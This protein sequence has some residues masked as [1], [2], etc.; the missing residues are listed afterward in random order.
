MSQ[1]LKDS[2][3][4][5]PGALISILLIAA[6]IYFVDIPK[7]I[8]AI[9]AANYVII[10]IAFV[11]G[12]AWLWVRAIVWRTLLRERASFWDVFHSL[13]VGYLLNAFLPLRLGELG[14]AYLLSLK[15]DMTFVEIL[16]TIVIERSMDLAITAAI[17]LSALPFVAGVKDADRIAIILGV[18][19]LAGLLFLY[20]L[21]RNDQW[22]LDT[23]HKVSAR[24]PS[25]QR[26]GG[27]ILESFL[28]GLGALTNGWLFARFMFWMLLNWGMS[29][30]TFYLVLI[31]FFP[32][33]QWIWALFGLGAGAFGNAVPSLPGAVGTYEGALGGALTLVSNDQNTSLAVALTLHFLNY[34]TAIV[35]GGYALI[36][37]GQSLSGVY[38][39]L[40]N[41]RSKGKI[42]DGD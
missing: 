31:A 32:H 42:A 7:M 21:A 28:T 13:N 27:S 2:K 20:I 9:R 12:F 29:I 11:I 8:A 24:W 16:P 36:R 22:A 5:L 37:G 17:F 19:V 1:F 41:L 23:F 6:I 3:R 30:V 14:R 15:T 39:Q 26:F 10:L 33:P 35:L 18:M 34:L 4:W 40:M 25:I 38:Q